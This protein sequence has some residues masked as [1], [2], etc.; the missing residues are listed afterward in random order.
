[1]TKVIQRGSTYTTNTPKRLL[2][3]E[4]HTATYATW[5]CS[6]FDAV[7]KIAINAWEKSMIIT[8]V[9]ILVVYLKSTKGKASFYVSQR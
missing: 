9:S 1:M 8:R 4:A 6:L 3:E 7:I 5:W 2:A